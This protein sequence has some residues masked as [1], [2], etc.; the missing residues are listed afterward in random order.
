MI[1][2]ASKRKII[3]N[4][5]IIGSIF[6][7]AG[8]SFAQSNSECMD[9]HSDTELES[10]RPDGSIVSAFVDTSV[11]NSSI[12]HQIELECMSCHID[13]EEIPHAE[14][15]EPVDCSMCHD[16][17]SE[18]YNLSLHGYALE[19]GNNN[20]PNCSSCHG[21]HNIFSSSDTLS[22]AN[23]FNLPQTCGECHNQYQSRLDPEIHTPRTVD[24]FLGSIHG[25]NLVEGI[26]KSA[27]CIDCHGSHALKGSADIESSVNKRNIPQTCSKCHD[28]IN[29]EYKNS[30]H[31]KALVVGIKDTPVCTDCHGEHT[32]KSISDPAAPTYILSLSE[33]VCSDCHEDPDI[34]E[35][36]GLPSA[37]L[38]TYKDSYH[39]LASRAGSEDVATCIS[40]HNS[41]N[42]LPAANVNSSV[43]SGK[44]TE[45]C[46]KCHPD[47]D[48]N[49]SRSYT[50]TSQRAETNPV[51]DFVKKFYI[52][53]II[54]VI[55]GMI[56]HN[57]VIMSKFIRDKY[58]S[59]N[60]R[61]TI[62]RF[63]KHA[64]VQ[65]F[66]LI[67]SFFILVITGF[68]L[69]F[70]DAW[71]VNALT[72]LGFTEAARGITHRIAG[73]ILIFASVYHIIYLIAS[74]RGRT[75]FKHLV[76]RKKDLT[77][78][79]DNMSFHL[80]IKRFHVHFDK[81]DYM[82]KIEYWALILGTLIMVIS[83]FVLWFP[84]FF[85]RFLP[86]W[87]LK[88]FET[89]HYLEAWLATLSLIFWHFF[90][91]IFHPD[92]YPMRLS[93]LHGK[94]TAN[95]AEQHYSNWFRKLVKEGKIKESE[96]NVAK[97]PDDD[98]EN[99]Q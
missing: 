74:I 49:F 20:A 25:T 59:A 14:D 71:W 26:E 15:L 97:K 56:V 44:V 95:K 87:A 8:I 45:T 7:S 6:F 54:V 76:F 37:T 38:Y 90:L 61:P 22:T 63:E 27:S 35:K 65:H 5:L 99:D 96:L 93:W 89:I 79:K 40:C 31:W 28:E 84:E 52:T 39:G 53:L 72:S 94:M 91:I 12:H 64:I 1:V 3:S 86:F 10:V 4:F 18:I 24:I 13:I 36:Y 34:I 62:N 92:E 51:D 85:T 43:H 55:S 11:Y 48:E 77:N 78:F 70:P 21:K 47:A 16:D 41:H 50:H 33:K 75:E 69:K 29:S 19:R 73:V 82:E 67:I 46:Q 23:H 17:V 32:I 58:Q 42:I 66:L 9:C 83:G 68:G 57:S 60:F 88:V 2:K 98:N 80:G 30:I 81:F